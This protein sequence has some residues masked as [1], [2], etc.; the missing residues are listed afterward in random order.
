MTWPLL[1]DF[2]YLANTDATEQVLQSTY[3]APEGTDPYAALLL[4]QLQKIDSSTI[5]SIPTT[6]SVEEHIGAWKKQKDLPP[7]NCQ[8]FHLV[9]TKW[10]VKISAF[11]PLIP[12]FIHFHTNTALHPHDRNRLPMSSF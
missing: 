3:Q 2:G 8:D 12:L 11:Q 10:L 7:L 1:L 5:P 4:N 9:T 6:L